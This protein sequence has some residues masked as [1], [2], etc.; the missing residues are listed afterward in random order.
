MDNNKMLNRMSINK[1]EIKEALKGKK[2]PNNLIPNLYKAYFS[3]VSKD[4]ILGLLR[5]GFTF[6]YADPK[7][8]S[9]DGYM[10]DTYTRLGMLGGDVKKVAMS[11]KMNMPLS[12]LAVMAKNGEDSALS[13]DEMYVMGWLSD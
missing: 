7:N 1:S 6:E 9:S 3:Q 12:E 8:R 10:N 2:E 5:E 4:Q 11:Y 13:S